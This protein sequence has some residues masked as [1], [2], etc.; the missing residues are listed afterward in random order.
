MVAG[1]FGGSV[2]VY[3][4]PQNSA[5]N[6]VPVLTLV[7]TIAAASEPGLALDAAGNIWVVYVSTATGAV[8]LTR[9]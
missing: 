4:T 6:A 1:E 9:Y 8:M 7:G 2:N 3:K 5:C